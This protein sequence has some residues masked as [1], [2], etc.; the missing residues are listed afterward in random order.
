MTSDYATTRERLLKEHAEARL[1]RD[2]A[3]HGSDAHR[4]AHA[5]EHHGHAAFVGGVK[6]LPI[7]YTL[8]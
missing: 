8:R 3:E 7:R 4:K 2:A 1:R 6:H 5:A